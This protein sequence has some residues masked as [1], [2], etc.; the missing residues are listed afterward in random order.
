MLN[1]ENRQSQIML[2]HC[3]IFATYLQYIGTL[4]KGDWASLLNMHSF[5]KACKRKQLQTSAARGG[6]GTTFFLPTPSLFS[7]F[8]FSPPTLYTFH[9]NFCSLQACLF[10]HSLA[11]SPHLENGKE[12]SATQTRIGRGLANSEFFK[13]QTTRF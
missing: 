3:K 8:S 2:C 5:L 10:A 13:Q 1:V 12:T 9:P 4:L 6:G 7:S 11:R